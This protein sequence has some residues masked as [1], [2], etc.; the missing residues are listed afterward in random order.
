MMPIIQINILLYKTERQAKTEWGVSRREV[1]RKR[2]MR[3]KRMRD[4]E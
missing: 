3:I 2:E 4:R 1:E